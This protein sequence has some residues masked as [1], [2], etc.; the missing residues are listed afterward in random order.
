MSSATTEIEGSPPGHRRDGCT[1]CVA[2]ERQYGL[3]Y[4]QSHREEKKAAAREYNKAHRRERNA[5]ALE[6]KR[7]NPKKNQAIR[8]RHYQT[9]TS[10]K[11]EFIREVVGAVCVDCGEDRIGALEYHHPDGRGNHQSLIQKGWQA[12]K[13]EVMHIIALCGSCHNIR[14]AKLVP[15]EPAESGA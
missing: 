11:R 15:S 14:H 8:L 10:E 6:W 7:R 12:L 4:Y 2:Y 9:S 3:T 1:R 13:E 5:Y